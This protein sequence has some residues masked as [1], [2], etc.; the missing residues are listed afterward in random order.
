MDYGNSRYTGQVILS[1]VGEIVQPQ[2]DIYR[3]VPVLPFMT[4]E[5]ADLLATAEMTDDTPSCSHREAVDKQDLFINGALA[6]FGA[7]MLLHL[8]RKMMT[9]NRGV[10]VNLSELETRSL[11]VG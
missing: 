5:F 6:Q 9:K 4:D 1:T 10:F 11:K 8:F 3:T 7:T 2:S